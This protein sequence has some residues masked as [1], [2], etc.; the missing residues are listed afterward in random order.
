MNRTFR[1]ILK[2]LSTDVETKVGEL[3]YN[4]L[5]ELRSCLAL[6]LSDYPRGM[7]DGEVNLGNNQI[8]CGA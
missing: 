1:F 5:E 7:Q 2:P 8:T 3:K 6:K 4:L